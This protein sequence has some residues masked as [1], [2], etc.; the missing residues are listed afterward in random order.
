MECTPDALITWIALKRYPV[1]AVKQIRVHHYLSVGKPKAE[2]LVR[3]RKI[4]FD[5]IAL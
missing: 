2:Y 1:F 4:V 5:W 3:Q